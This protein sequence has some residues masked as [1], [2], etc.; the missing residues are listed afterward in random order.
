LKFIKL[1]YLLIVLLFLFLL[2]KF[3]LSL[4]TIPFPYFLTSWMCGMLPKS[5]T[6]LSFLPVRTAATV[7]DLFPLLFPSRYG[8]DFLNFSG[9][10]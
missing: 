5:L 8:M 10:A 9:M 3:D 6:I 7:P 2:S 1:C 4:S